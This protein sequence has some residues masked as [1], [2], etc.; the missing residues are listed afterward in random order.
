MAQLRWPSFLAS[1]TVALLTRHL[2]FCGLHRSHHSWLID[3]LTTWG[4]SPLFFMFKYLFCWPDQLDSIELGSDP[5]S[6]IE[7]LIRCQ[8]FLAIES[9]IISSLAS[10][11][12][13]GIRNQD[14]F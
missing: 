6:K 12:T 7:I 10:V 8:D 3:L 2:H 5:L 13:S 1:P 9:L 11:A 4:R 14:T